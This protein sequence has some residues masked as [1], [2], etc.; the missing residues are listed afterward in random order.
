MVL[1]SNTRVRRIRERLL[2]EESQLG[3]PTPFGHA[4]HH[5]DDLRVYDRYIL[6]RLA[7]RLIGSILRTKGM[8]KGHLNCTVLMSSPMR[9]R[10][11]TGRQRVASLTARAPGRGVMLSATKNPALAL[12]ETHHLRH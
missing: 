4:G 12:D 7:A 9:R 2:A 11:S 3:F 5:F 6:V 8:P 10:A 1:A